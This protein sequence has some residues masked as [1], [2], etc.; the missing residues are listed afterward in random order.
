M[1]PLCG[2]RNVL[3]EDRAIVGGGSRRPPP[4]LYNASCQV[5][6]AAQRRRNDDAD[7]PSKLRQQMWPRVRRGL[8]SRPQPLALAIGRKPPCRWRQLRAAAL[9]EDSCS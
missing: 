6:A 2:W 5:H 1:V 8:D 9:Q 3:S 4:Q 7:A